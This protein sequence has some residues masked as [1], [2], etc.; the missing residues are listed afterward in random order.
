MQRTFSIGVLA[1]AATV[2]VQSTALAQTGN[3][4]PEG[5]HIDAVSQ[6]NGALLL[7]FDV[8]VS[9]PGPGG[10]TITAS[11]ADLVRFDQPT[12]TF[13][14]FFDGAGEGIA[15]G[16]NLDGAGYLAAN[17][18]LLVSFDVSGTAGGI[19]FG[20][21]DILEFDTIAH[22]WAMAYEADQRDPSL[23]GVDLKAAF[24]RPPLPLLG[25][26]AV[27]F[28]PDI[29]VSFTGLVIHPNQVAIDDFGTG[30]ITVLN[31]PGVP[32]SAHVT[33]FA[34]SFGQYLLAFDT[35]V[36]L[37]G[38]AGATTVT[39]R[40]VAALNQLTN[41]YSLAFQGGSS[42]GVPP[43][44]PIATA[45]AVPP[46][47]ATPVPTLTPLPTS[48]PTSVPTSDPTALPTAVP[49]NTPTPVSTNPPTPLPTNTPSPTA[50][51]T[52]VPTPVCAAARASQ[53]IVFPP[54]GKLVSEAVVG[55]PGATIE[56]TSIRQD[57]PQIGLDL[58]CPDGSGVGTSTAMVRA[59][60]AEN[61]DGRV[62]HIGFTARDGN[63]GTC[64]SEVTVCVPH[65]QR[66]NSCVDGG[67]TFNSTGCL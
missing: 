23:R 26:A 30:N 25:G 13:T 56:I 9:L 59:E 66:S 4:I 5:A 48:V 12:S 60:R 43:P 16:M 52:S 58:K 3:G 11:P 38:L 21:E 24:A 61:G 22:T 40:D 41:A 28:A 51:P 50:T 7:S 32:E 45:T 14:I 6:V 10:A 2:A 63:G 49:T 18:D 31:L 27:G 42:T 35:T 1:V 47:T 15:E 53:P 44:T 54:N 33:G 17:S 34:E 20:P 64:S 8:T 46:P 39:P 65:D 36:T 55:I 62:Y 67:A 29:T 57:E 19:A 37:P